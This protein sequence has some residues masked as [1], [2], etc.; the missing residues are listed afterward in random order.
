MIPERLA[1]FDR[2]LGNGFRCIRRQTKAPLPAAATAVLPGKESIDYSK[3]KPVD[4]EVY[5]VF[6]RFFDR[7]PVPLEAR[8]ESTDDSSRH[9]VKQKVSYAAGYGGERIIAWLYLP[10]SARPPYQVMI[11]MAGASTFYRSRS[12]AKESE[13]FGWGY[14]EY[15]IRGGRAVLIPIWKGSYERQD[16]FHPF[17][18]DRAAYR[19]HTID[20]VT[21]IRQSVDYLQSRTDV[22][23]KA[24]GYQGISFGSIWGP[25]FLALEPRLRTGILLLGGFVVTHSTREPHPPEIQAYNYAPRVKVPVLMMSGRYDPIFP[26]QT[27]QVPLF[28]ALGTPTSQKSHLTFPA[29]HSTYGWRDQLYREGLNWLDRQ[30][31]PVAGAGSPPAVANR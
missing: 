31:G 23:P 17:E 13:I 29:G 9:W 19:D 6:T 7:K 24:I 3:T 15:L 5:E 25:V 8:I 20:W 14:A 10:R 28:R 30:F 16:G 11:Q 12:S 2:S 22:N 4:D 21:E 18:S 26:Y 1:P 27:A